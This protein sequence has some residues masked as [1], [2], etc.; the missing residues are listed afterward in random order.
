MARR[1]TRQNF[2]WLYVIL[3]NQRFS[4][5]NLFFRLVLGAPFHIEDLVFLAHKLFGI[6]VTAQT[7]LHL[8]RRRLVS[9]RHLIDAAVAG[10]TT[11]AF[12]HMNAVIEIDVVG[13]IVNA[14]PLDRFARAKAG[15][16]GLEVWAVGPDL[17]VTVHAHGRRR[18]AGRR[19]RFDGRV[20]IAAIDAVVADVV[21]VTELNWLVAFDPLAGVPR[22]TINLGGY[23]KR[24]EQNKNGSIDRSLGERVGTVMENLWH[25]RSWLIPN[26]SISNQRAV[27]NRKLRTA[28]ARFQTLRPACVYQRR[29]RTRK[30]LKL[31]CHVAR[32]VLYQMR[33][34]FQT[35][36]F[37]NEA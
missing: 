18:D 15:A 19:R 32:C 14:P 9:D 10:R 37:S 24:G 29:T 35:C 3:R 2:R 11:D 30:R 23:P 26:S 20:A 17:F 5:V 22:R 25:R 12:V 7:P 1:A 27:E 34:I 8:Q 33:E 31:S 16:D 28:R 6:S 21:F 4:F 36:I 13:Q